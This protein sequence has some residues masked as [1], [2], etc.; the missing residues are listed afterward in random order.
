MERNRNRRFPLRKETEKLRVSVVS[1]SR[2]LDV[3]ERLGRTPGAICVQPREGKASRGT[4]PTVDQ[5]NRYVGDLHKDCLI[6]LL[7]SRRRGWIRNTAKDSANGILMK[8]RKSRLELEEQRVPARNNIPLHVTA[9]WRALRKGGIFG[10][11]KTTEQERISNGFGSE[12]L[13]STLTSVP[14]TG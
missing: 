3:I 10:H 14:K 8:L 6:K 9:L 5:L 11:I 2:V 7:R 4:T 1:V 12:N 13:R